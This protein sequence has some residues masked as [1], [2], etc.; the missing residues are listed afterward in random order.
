MKGVIFNLLEEVVSA[1]YGEAV[2]DDLLVAAGVDGAYASL[3]LYPDAELTAIVGALA[4]ATGRAPDDVLR[5][6]GREALPRWVD[7]VPEVFAAHGDTRALVLALNDVIHPEV[8]KLDAAAEVPL[9]AFDLSDPAVLAVGYRSSRGL[10]AFAEGLVEGTARHFGEDVAIAQPRCQHRGDPL[11][12][13]EVRF[14]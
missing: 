13:L 6:A 10:C 11:C 14:A 3:G 7:R 5:W 4:E 1:A 8:R 2:W 9:F 12:R